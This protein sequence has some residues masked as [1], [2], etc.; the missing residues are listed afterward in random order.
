MFGSPA[1]RVLGRTRCRWKDNKYVLLKVGGIRVT[2]GTVARSC[3]D[4]IEL[5][6]SAIQEGLVLCS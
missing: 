4:D 1:G 6:D 5:P 3:K 2:Q